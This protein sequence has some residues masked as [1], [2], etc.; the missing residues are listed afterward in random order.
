[1]REKS[2][3]GFSLVNIERRN[4]SENIEKL[5]INSWSIII[6]WNNGKKE[7]IGNIDDETAN[8]V[9]EYLDDYQNQVNEEL[10]GKYE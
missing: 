1:L 2:P 10:R 9:Q 3:P 8:K 7:D 4:M 6:T 5:E